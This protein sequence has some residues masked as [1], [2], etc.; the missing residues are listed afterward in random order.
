M[1]IFESIIRKAEEKFSLGS[2][3][4]GGLMSG[5]LGLIISDGGL[6]EFLARFSNAGLASTVDSWI[7]DGNN[8]PLSDQQIESALGADTL[9]TL[10]NQA[11]V[12][13]ST[14]TSVMATVI[15]QVVD[16]LTP[17][18]EIP[19]DNEK[20]LSKLR[21]Y[22]GGL[23]G[24]AGAT[25]T[26]AFDRVGNA[27]GDAFEKGKDAVYGEIDSVGNAAGALGDSGG[28]R[29][30]A[31]GT[32]DNL[33]TNGD[34]SV[35]RWLLP[36]LLLG[37]LVA[38]GFWFCGKSTPTTVA[39]NTGNINV[40]KTNSNAIVVSNTNAFDSSFSIKAANG[41]YTVTG[42]IP[43]EAMKKQI[44]DYFSYV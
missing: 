26:G 40:N 30:N 31:I 12:E 20:M 18:G 33:D 13:R 32:D 25:A 3:K 14:A 4:A 34:S 44:V 36:L 10:A 42:V 16:R 9:S 29:V 35:L 2:G 28:S 21:G 23:G 15:P 19:N 22:I 27:T 38:L 8:T 17:E 37:L 24:T 6:S 1:F 7:T 11:G 41:K 5:L 39:I 43:D